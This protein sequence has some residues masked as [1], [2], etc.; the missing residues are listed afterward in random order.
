MK[1]EKGEEINFKYNFKEYLSYL[2]NYKFLIFLLLVIVLVQE[3]LQILN[4]YLFKVI[5]DKGT[6]FSAG[7]LVLEKFVGILIIVGIVYLVAILI[8]SS[9]LAFT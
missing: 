7:T 5:I 1:T 3:S 9:S 4:R 8:S 2:K 6:D